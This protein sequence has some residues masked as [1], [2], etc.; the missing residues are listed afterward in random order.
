MRGSFH[1]QPGERAHPGIVWVGDV[2]GE[3]GLVSGGSYE[4]L[5]LSPLPTPKGLVM[6]AVGALL[7][8]SNYL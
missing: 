8:K 2:G 6:L 7:I 4:V 5:G 1:R 3:S